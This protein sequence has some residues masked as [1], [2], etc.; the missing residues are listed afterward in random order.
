MNDFITG[1]IVALCGVAALSFWHFRRQTGERFFGLF[2]F[3]FAT[4][5]VNFVF[6]AVGDRESEFRPTL[7]LIRLAAFLLIITAIVEKNRDA[8]ERP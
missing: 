1:A 7:Y 2:A 6:L 4:L 5:G 8:G 3:A